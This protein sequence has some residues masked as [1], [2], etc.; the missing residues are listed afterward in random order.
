MSRLPSPVIAHV[1]CMCH[2]FI[3]F[4]SGLFDVAN[5]DDEDEAM[6]L[7]WIPLLSML[8]SVPDETERAMGDNSSWSPRSFS[9][10]F[11]SL[12]IGKSC[13]LARI[14]SGVPYEETKERLAKKLKN[15]LRKTHLIVWTLCCSHKLHF[16]FLHSFQVYWIDYENDSV[17]AS[18]VTSPKRSQLLL[19]SN[20]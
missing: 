6:L 19:P 11:G 5:E 4:W 18:R 8:E 12:A 16:S 1:G 2:D 7:S 20:I 17:G 10:S 15:R 14:K 9:N 3:G 13:L